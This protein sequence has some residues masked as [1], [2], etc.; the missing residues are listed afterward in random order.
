MSAQDVWY[1]SHVTYNRILSSRNFLPTLR[2]QNLDYT[3][4]CVCVR[5]HAGIR[6]LSACELLV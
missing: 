4:V 6:F 2:L 5:V 1:S 3:W